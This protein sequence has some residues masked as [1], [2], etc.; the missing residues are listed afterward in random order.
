[1]HAHE[2]DAAHGM[3]RIGS[4]LQDLVNYLPGRQV[5]FEPQPAGGAK[6]TAE[7]AANLRADANHI[8]AV[9]CPVQERNADRFERLRTVSPEQVLGK[10]IERGNRLLQEVQ[11]WNCCCPADPIEKAG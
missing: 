3:S 10:A 2:D 11:A 4:H 7:S 6:C 9:V 5:A 1:S 8:F